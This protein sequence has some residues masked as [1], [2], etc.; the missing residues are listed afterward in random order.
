[1]YRKVRDIEL[2]LYKKKLGMIAQ[3]DETSIKTNPL[4]NNVST[5]IKR[6]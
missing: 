1:M 4:N 3:A 2:K 5:S 6:R